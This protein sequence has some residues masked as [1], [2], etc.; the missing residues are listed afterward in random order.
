MKVLE[1]TEE[2]DDAV[3]ETTASALKYLK[4]K[5]EQH[6]NRRQRGEII[7]YQRQ[8]VQTIRPIIN[9]YKEK[10]VPWG[11]SDISH[12]SGLCKTLE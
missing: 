4:S 7:R 12:S 3:K 9:Q 10:D 8:K 6:K 5:Y 1:N 2:T 11:L